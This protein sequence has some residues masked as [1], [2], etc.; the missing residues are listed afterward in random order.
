MRSLR[1]PLVV[2]LLS[3]AAATPA[4][5]DTWSVLKDSST[6][7][8]RPQTLDLELIIG[9]LFG[10]YNHFGLGGWYGYPILP[11]GFIPKI[12]D[13]FYIEAGAAVER[14]SYGTSFVTSCNETWWRVSPAGGVRWQF[15]LTQ[16]WSAFATAK[17]G[18]GIGFADSVDC[19]S[20]H[21]AGT[22]NTSQ[23]IFDT[24]LGAYW[25]FAENWRMRFDLGYYSSLAVGAG[26][27]ISK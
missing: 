1:I 6:H 11:D 19:G 17:A 8:S 21:L 13:A 16:D 4:H 7:D 14:F 20:V 23:F 24:G 27:D 3:F 9:Y 2:A 26:T 22:A 12:N 5:A 18:F 25:N 15:N 10:S